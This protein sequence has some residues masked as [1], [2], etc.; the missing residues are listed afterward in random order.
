MIL[1]HD[2]PDLIWLKQRINER[3][4]V[5][6]ASDQRP[7]IKNGW[8]TVLL[9]V[10]TK[11]AYRD[12][13]KGPFSLFYNIEGFSHVKIAE[14]TV[15]VR[16]GFFFLTNTEQP[17]SLEI[18][19]SAETF[20]IHF[21]EQLIDEVYHFTQQTLPYLLDHPIYEAHAPF[22]FFNRL[23]PQNEKIRG[24]LLRL[25]NRGQQRDL[26][27]LWLEEQLY[28]LLICLLEVTQADFQRIDQLPLVKKASR[29]EVF[30]RLTLAVDLVYAAYDRAISLSELA[31]A[32][33]LSKYHFLRLFKMAFGQ[34]PH[35]FISSVRIEKA[36][37]W[38][39]YSNKPIHLIA[40]GIGLENTSSLS[41]LFNQKTGSYP[42]EY[43]AAF[44]S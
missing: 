1:R 20:N 39:R 14:R 19:G 15:D 31:D 4:Q 10:K 44:R 32:V 25:H 17:Y 36:K 26:E 12:D 21:G 5:S 22:H 2:F 43:R 13:V 9:N 33:C 34:S 6:V 35:Q 23:Y 27:P 8:P 11:Q 7:L 16:P 30:R 3:F 42:S 38:L 29:E 28:E 41:R 24:L 40:N 18:G 37:E